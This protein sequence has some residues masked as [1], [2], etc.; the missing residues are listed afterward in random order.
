MDKSINIK[1]IN[2]RLDKMLLDILYLALRVYSCVCF[3][4]IA[5]CFSVM[6]LWTSVCNRLND[7]DDWCQGRWIIDEFFYEIKPD[8]YY[9]C[10]GGW[11]LPWKVFHRSAVE[12]VCGEC[13]TPWTLCRSRRICMDVLRCV[14]GTASYW[15]ILPL[16]INVIIVVV[17]V[18][19][20]NILSFD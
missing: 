17:V 20:N 16:S 18:V 14:P 5:S 10:C 3:V 2:V 13:S 1:N 8:R 19:F 12:C 9:C 6:Q 7:N 15:V 4:V 11:W